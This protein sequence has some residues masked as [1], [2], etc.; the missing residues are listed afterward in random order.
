VYGASWTAPP[1]FAYRKGVQS[2]RHGTEL[3]S[4]E[5]ETYTSSNLYPGKLPR[6]FD[7][8]AAAGAEL[9]AYEPGEPVTA[10]VPPDAPGNAFLQRESS[11]Q[12]FLVI[13]FGAL[14]VVGAIRS[15]LGD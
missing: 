14:F 10:Y 9:E 13:G 1:E 6:E 4:Y 7:T 5:G 2:E 12:P 8:R 3:Y 11:N 15:A